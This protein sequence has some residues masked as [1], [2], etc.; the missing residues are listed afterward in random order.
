MMETARAINLFGAAK[1]K[2]NVE[3]SADL[4]FLG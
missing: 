3:R 4:L 1:M 2:K